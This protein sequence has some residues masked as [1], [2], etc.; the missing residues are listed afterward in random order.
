M[1]QNFP[2]PPNK[3]YLCDLFFS[4]IEIY[5]KLIYSRKNYIMFKVEWDNETGGVKLNSLH[6]K[7]SLSV[8]PRPVFFEELDLLKLNDLGWS[9]PKCNEPLLWACNKQYFYRGELVFEAKGANIYDAPT[10]IFADGKEK[11]SLEP[12]D[13]K[14]MLEHCSDELFLAESEAIEFIRDVYVQYSSARKS[15]EKVKANQIDYEALVAKIEK[16]TK[17]KMAI[18]KQDCDSFDIM[19]LANA[20]QEGKRTYA[21]TKIDVFL[22]SFS[23]GKDSQVV[24]DL[25]TRAIPPQSFEVIYSDTG[26]ELPTSLQLYEEV[27]KHYKELYPE[28]RFRIARNHESVLNYWDKIGT[29]SDTH[30]WCCSVMKTAP[31]YKLLK[32]EGTNKQA[33]VLTFDGVRAEESTKR[34]GYGRIGKG[35]KHSTVINAR[36]ILDWNTTEIFLYLFRHNLPINKSYRQ[37][38][39][40]VGCIICPFGSEW[41]EMVVNNLYHNNVTPFIS[42]IENFSEKCGVKDVDEYIKEGG[43]KRRSSGDYIKSDSH[44][45]FQNTR[46]NLRVK[47]R[48]PH[49]KIETFFG[50]IGEYVIKNDGKISKGQL[51]YEHTIYSFDIENK[52]G[53]F[54]CNIYNINDPTLIGLIK[55]CLMKATYCIRCTAC[56]VECP[57]GALEIYPNTSIDNERCIHCHKCLEHYEKGCIVANSLYK[58]NGNMNTKT[59]DKYKNFGLKTEWLEMYF[60]EKNNF[61]NINHGLN[62][63]YQV[64]A[65]KSWLKDASIIDEKN[66]I[67]PIGELLSVVQIDFYNLPWEIVWI[68]LSYNSF[69]VNWFVN[70]VKN[71]EN[72]NSKYLEDLLKNQYSDYKDK[73]VHNAVYQLLR[74]L[75]ESPIG[76]MGICLEYQNNYTREPYDDLSRE[77]IAYSLYKYAEYVGTKSLRV[78]DLYQTDCK[79]GVYREFGIS[80]SA[81]ESQLRSLNSD[82]NRVLVAELNMGLDSITLRDDLN[83]IEA[84]KILTK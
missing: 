25:C 71:G 4:H 78:S 22:A 43:W 18:V 54:E 36:P 66:N 42:K 5:K 17:Q 83:A 27:Q 21:T 30:R 26:Y 56:E 64:P 8:S 15:V 3:D 9:Y 37:G 80:R 62:P 70:N 34:S 13:V 6:T 59:I 49:L 44:I 29:P 76:S 55:R 38:M 45:D 67:T 81:L 53:S 69:I 63:N 51:K 46:P 75:K 79:Q 74:T 47:I 58:T 12:V 65:L 16:Q 28:L 57:V 60:T 11:L 72:Y 1:S 48:N 24:L 33:K 14:T 10:I 84:L 61:W 50:A 68:N 39:T 40:R 2:N 19:P 32:I 20:K 52:D 31:L 41:N 82:T 35:V 73:T 7:N 23:G 77:A